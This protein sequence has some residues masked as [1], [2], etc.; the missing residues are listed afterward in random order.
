MLP[1]SHFAP[2]LIPN[3][4]KILDFTVLK[5]GIQ[6]SHIPFFCPDYFLI[7]N[8]VRA[9]DWLNHQDR[10]LSFL[11]KTFSSWTNYYFYTN[12]ASLSIIIKEASFRKLL[13][14]RYICHA[15]ILLILFFIFLPYNC[16]NCNGIHTYIQDWMIS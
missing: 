16:A 15:H 13:V 4:S 12:S 2:Q 8:S 5:I 14:K 11:W 6:G 10:N 7:S 1:L 9:N 3:L